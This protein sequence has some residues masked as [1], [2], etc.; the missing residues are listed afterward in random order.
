MH[1]KVVVRNVRKYAHFQADWRAVTSN[2][3]EKLQVFEV[4][5]TCLDVTEHQIEEKRS[6][7]YG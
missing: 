4:P 2:D 6:P 1:N 5:P 3:P 7:F